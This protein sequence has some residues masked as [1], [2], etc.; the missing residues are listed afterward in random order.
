MLSESETSV[1]HLPIRLVSYST[2][3]QLLA[4]FFLIIMTSISET[5]I[6]YQADPSKT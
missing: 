4:L 6:A 1:T 2:L 3:P 5:L